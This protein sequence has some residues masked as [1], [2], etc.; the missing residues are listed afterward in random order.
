M[1]FFLILLFIICNSVYADDDISISQPE[2]EYFKNN[3]IIDERILSYPKMLDLQYA[4]THP[5]FAYI[6]PNLE[7]AKIDVKNVA[8]SFNTFFSNSAFANKNHQLM[9]F[10]GFST[11]DGGFERLIYGSGKYK[12][13]LMY[14]GV[15]YSQKSSFFKVPARLNLEFTFFNGI[16]DG[17]VQRPNGTWHS[18]DYSVY[19]QLAAGVSQDLILGWKHFYYAP[20][21]GI[22]MKAKNKT[23]D[24]ISSRLHFGVRNAVG[25][26]IGALNA[27]IFFRHFSNGSITDQNSGQNFVGVALGFKF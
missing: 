9:V 24:R 10:G 13:N 15:V 16:K 4:F 3:A 25:T 26:N 21:L 5:N 22:Y 1:R 7:Y 11:R 12:Y 17:T 27:E 20:G 8:P 2:D 23:D 14:G 6:Q 18:R 19:N